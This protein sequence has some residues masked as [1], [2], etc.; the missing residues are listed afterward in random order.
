M[1][2]NAAYW[3][4]KVRRNQER[5]ASNR[6]ALE[7]AGWTVKTIWA[8]EARDSQV[9]SKFINGIRSVPRRGRPAE[10]AAKSR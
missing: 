6:A 8:C 7:A 2:A 9:L 10:G 5:D 3:Q 4:Q 1:K